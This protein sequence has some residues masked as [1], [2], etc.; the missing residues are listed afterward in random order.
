[1]PKAS[2]RAAQASRHVALVALPDAVVSTLAGLYDVM[3]AR[4][5]TGPADGPAPFRAEIVGESLGPLQWASGVPLP[6]Q[7]AIDSVASTDIVIVPSV[8]LREAT[9]CKGRYPKL[10]AWLKRMHERGAVLC[11]A[12]SGIF[13]LAETG[14]FDGK[15]ATV[16]FGYVREFAAAHPAVPIHPERVLVVSGVRESWSAPAHRPPG[17]TWC[18]T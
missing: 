1:M 5:L 14:L 8:L 17:T 11:S 18:C 7:R 2:T 13:L 6:V 10:V 9:W 16:H 3:N 15:D 12:C 4:A